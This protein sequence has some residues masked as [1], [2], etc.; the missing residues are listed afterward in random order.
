MEA[1][2]LWASV[3]PVCHPPSLGSQWPGSSPRHPGEGEQCQ[4]SILERRHWG[5]AGD[6]LEAFHTENWQNEIG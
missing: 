2:G 4:G 1:G 6:G 5:W 3:R